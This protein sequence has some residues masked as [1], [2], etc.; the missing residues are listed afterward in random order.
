MPVVPVGVMKCLVLVAF[1]KVLRIVVLVFLTMRCPL[2]VVCLSEHAVLV[3]AMWDVVQVL[4]VDRASTG[5]SL[6]RP[7]ADAPVGLSS[8]LG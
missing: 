1:L 5:P 7:P 2:L 3:R 6:A 4:L 8:G